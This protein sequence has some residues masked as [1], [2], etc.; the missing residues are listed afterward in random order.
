MISTN[1]DYKHKHLALIIISALLI[2]ILPFYITLGWE[3]LLIIFLLYNL[4][5]GVGSEI[6]AHRLW[7]HRSFETS[8]LWERI[9]IVLNTLSGEGSILAFAGVHRLHH[10]YSDTDRDPHNP[11]NDLWKTIF[12]QHNTDEFDGKII[13][14]LVRDRWLIFQHKNYFEIQSVIVLTLAL[15]SP[16]ALWYYAVNVWMT[17]WINFLVNVVCHR[18]GPAD[19]LQSNTSTNNLWA[20]I[21]LLGANLHNNHHAEPSRYNNAWGRNRFDLWGSI[22]ELIKRK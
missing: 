13:R 20:G 11:H 8:W 22:I 9:I 10:R 5:K 19:N 18:Y 3:A 21:F 4:T 12:Y 14:D 6:G 7:S 16:T 15:I 1:M 2:V 17:L